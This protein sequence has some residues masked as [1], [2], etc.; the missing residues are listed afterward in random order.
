MIESDPSW[1]A[2][3]ARKR[4]LRNAGLPQDP[5][6]ALRRSPIVIY[7]SSRNNY[8]MLEGEVLRNIDF[9]GIPFINIDDNSDNEQ[10]AL[11]KD[12][13][14]RNNIVF[15]RNKKRGLQWAL[16]TVSHYLEK[17][18]SPATWVIHITHD[19]FPIVDDFYSIIRNLVE[20]GKLD[21]FGCLGFNHIDFRTTPD[22]VTA[23]KS[24]NK[25]CG[26]VGRAVLSKLP[27][28]GVLYKP[29]LIPLPWKK[30]G[31]PFVVESVV[32]VMVGINLSL[33]RKLKIEA[34]ENFTL[35]VWM[36]DICMQFLKYGHFNLVIPEL[37]AF[38]CQMLKDKYNIPVKSARSAR[39]GD[40]Y[41][42][43]GFGEHL[44]YWKE[45]W[46]W[47]REDRSTFEKVRQRYSGK[48]I[49]EFYD[50]DPS[51]GPYKSLVEL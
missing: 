5:A 43:Q 15:L 26:I 48:L 30:W 2:P 3:S 1:I 47:D 36:D 45:K 38:N 51:R 49:E 21:D 13:C 40:K 41:F 44:A 23:W 24:G 39:E 7:A 20:S 29:G 46:G 33:Y 16:R 18:G 50:F 9:E 34:S 11:G 14:Q 22:S 28:N 37:V 17:I 32:D 27:T 10:V 31:R 4:N 25:V 35:H 42:Y 12:I 19:D 6:T 8:E